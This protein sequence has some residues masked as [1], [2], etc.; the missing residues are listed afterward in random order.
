MKTFIFHFAMARGRKALIIKYGKPFWF[1]FKR[2][3]WAIFREL[4]PEL[5]YLGRS[6]FSFNFQFAPAY[7]AWYRALTELGLSRDEAMEVIWLLNE[8]LVHPAAVYA[9]GGQGQFSG[10]RIKAPAHELRQK[11]GD[12]HVVEDA[13]LA[14]APLGGELVKVG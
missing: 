3:S 8:P 9:Q 1:D 7:T 12:Q 5:P 6:L 13:M 4:A 10:F 14:E 2:R 11:R